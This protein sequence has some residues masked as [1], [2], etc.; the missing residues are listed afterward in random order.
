MFDQI[1]AQRA[2]VSKDSLIVQALGAVD[3]LNSYLGVVK[4]A[5]L[6]PGLTKTIKNI[7]DNLLKIGSITGGSSLQF[8]ETNTKHLEKLIDELEG[9]LPPLTNFVFPGGSVVSSHLQ[10]ARTL[11]RKTER[12]FVTLKSEVKV[13]P[14]ILTYLNRLSDAL[15]M[16]AREA[17]AKLGITEETWKG[18]K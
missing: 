14:A 5:S 12:A 8:R 18:K 1:G 11:A 16:L 2:R 7:Q 6:M 3:E 10:Y 17:N 4:A 15:F 13:K 9:K